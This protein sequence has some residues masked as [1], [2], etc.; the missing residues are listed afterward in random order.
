MTYMVG[1]VAGTTGEITVSF[2]GTV[3]T[4]G[5]ATDV[6]IAGVLT[7]SNQGEVRFADADGSHHVGFEAPATVSANQIWTLPDAD[8]SAD[9][10]LKTDGSGNLGWA[11]ASAA[12]TDSQT[13]EAHGYARVASNTGLY[14]RVWDGVTSPCQWTYSL[15]TAPATAASG[16]TMSLTVANGM[17]YTALWMMPKAGSVQSIY[18]AWYQ[19]YY[20]GRFRVR[21]WKCTPADNSSSNQTWTAM[22]TGAIN[23]TAGKTVT[24]TA[25]EDLSSDSNNGV[26]AGDLLAITWDGRNIGGTNYGSSNSN[27]RTTFNLAVLVNWS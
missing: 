13:F 16:D 11:S 8:G 25:A 27:N 10:V 22:G 7:T 26:S 6:T 9:Q 20:V 15:G 5:L 19:A 23:A 3:A 21:V 17:A 18:A 4:V 24:H 1:D 12:G 2:S 14:G